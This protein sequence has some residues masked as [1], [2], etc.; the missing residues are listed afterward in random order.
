MLTLKRVNNELEKLGIAERLAKGDEYFF[1][2]DGNAH[3]WFQSG[4][5]AYRLNQLTLE[6]WIREHE[7]LSNGRSVK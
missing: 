1:F 5:Y 6:Q 7:I 3:T 4:V 2:T